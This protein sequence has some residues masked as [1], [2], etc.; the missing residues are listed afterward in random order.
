LR[1]KAFIGP[2]ENTPKKYFKVDKKKCENEIKQ[3]SQ[4]TDLSGIF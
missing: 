4:S 1:I 2:N 3:D